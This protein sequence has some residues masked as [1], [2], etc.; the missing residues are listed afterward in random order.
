VVRNLDIDMTGFREAVLVEG[1]ASVRPL[2]QRCI[3]R[4]ASF[5]TTLCK[6]VQPR[7]ISCES[8]RKGSVK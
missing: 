8:D 6:L 3:I 4:S 5:C 2:L 7:T 1:K